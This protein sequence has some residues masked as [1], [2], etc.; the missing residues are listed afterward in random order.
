[1]KWNENKIKNRVYELLDLVNL[2]PSINAKK[3]PAQL[4][5][6]QRQRV[7][8]ARG[9]AADPDILLMDEPFGA[10]DP[11]NRET[12]QNG[13]LEIQEKI[14]KTIVFVTHDIREAIK[15]GD[16]IVI[17]NQGNIEQEG[18]TLE[19]VKNPKN[20]FVRNILGE[21]SEFKTLEFMKVS[22]SISDIPKTYDLDK[23]DIEKAK[24][25]DSKIIILTKEDKFFG[26]VENRSL[27]NLSTKKDLK[28][29]MKPYRLKKHL[30]LFDALN[31]ML[32]AGVSIL[33]VID[34]D[35]KVVGMIDFSSI[36]NNINS[37]GE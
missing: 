33:P 28:N 36:F 14:Q 30:S 12:L 24:Q 29:I 5:G 2:D 3:Y 31:I 8:V 21:D 13:F 25:D 11:I 18:S 20:Q 16:R 10:I 35:N 15:L 27:N 7:G 1:L 22:D 26:F 23:L 6:G 9:L 17:L 37:G 34:K 32:R 19:V 4:S